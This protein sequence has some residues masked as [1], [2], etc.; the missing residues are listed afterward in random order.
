MARGRRIDRDF[1]LLSLGLA[2][3]GENETE[4]S[5]TSDNSARKLLPSELCR[6]SS[7][8]GGH[9]LLAGWLAGLLVGLLA[10]R[11]AESL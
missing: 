4:L 8:S 3:L 11:P 5:A 10:G 9:L 7:L 1:G 2:W 6:R